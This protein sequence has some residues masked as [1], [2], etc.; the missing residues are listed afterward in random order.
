MSSV[1]QAM[2][3]SLILGVLLLSVPELQH[4]GSVKAKCTVCSTID[5]AV[6]LISAGQS[7]VLGQDS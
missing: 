7:C 4:E 6:W 1:L 5:Q 3:V 2:E